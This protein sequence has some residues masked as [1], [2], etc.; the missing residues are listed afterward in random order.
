MTPVKRIPE[1]ACARAVPGW[2]HP[3]R[4]RFRR[5]A[6]NV[7]RF[8]RVEHRDGA[9]HLAP[10][11]EAELRATAQDRARSSEPLEHVRQP[12]KRRIGLARS[13]KRAQ[14]GSVCDGV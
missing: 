3:D 4:P 8:S 1:N 14:F 12:N 10:S 11:Y 7:V 2:V 6:S 9:G 13:G 5:S